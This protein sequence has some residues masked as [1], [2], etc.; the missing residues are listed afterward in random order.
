M[1]AESL[2]YIEAV[3]RG[4]TTWVLLLATLFISGLVGLVLY[5]VQRQ[6]ASRTLRWL[7]SIAAATVTLV[8]SGLLLIVRGFSVPAADSSVFEARTSYVIEV[9]NISSPSGEALASFD[10]SLPDAVRI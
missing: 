6:V 10:I 1:I 4:A 5:A 3:A 9:R 8:F 7:M 2:F